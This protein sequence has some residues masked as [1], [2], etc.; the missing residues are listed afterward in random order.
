MRIR[1]PSPSLVISIIALVMASTG[2]AIAA[3]NYAR[4][5]GSVDGKSAVG[6]S[7]SLHH[8]A[9]HLVAT[10]RG[11]SHKSKIPVKFLA[12]VP[13]ST[14]FGRY[15]PV[16]DNN[17]GG[18]QVLNASSLG[19]LSA[20][21][22]DQ[23][24]RAGVLDPTTTLTFQSSGKSVNFARS[25]GGANATVVPMAPNTSQTIVVNGSNTF[26][27]QAESFG[28][29]VIYDGQVRQDGR[30]SGTANCLVAGTAETF[31]P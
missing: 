6:A 9:G 10:A 26:H 27:V 25:I 13:A 18:S 24:N 28:T 30:G 23:D 3:V 19:T 12:N 4:K 8:A 17:T 21:C 20:T 7:A 31:T 16:V 5:A 22:N 11:G 29:D 15:A 14:T 1:K 2:S